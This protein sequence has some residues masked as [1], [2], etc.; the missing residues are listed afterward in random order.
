MIVAVSL[1]PLSAAV[2][3]MGLVLLAV[4][5]PPRRTPATMYFILLNLGLALWALAYAI[6]LNLAPAGEVTL[7]AYGTTRWWLLVA[8]VVGSSAGFTYWFLFGAA[9][10]EHG[11]WVRPAGIALAHVPALYAIAVVLTNARFH[12]F[13]RVVRGHVAYGLPAIPYQAMTFLLSLAGSWMVTTSVLRRFGRRSAG[14]VG[15]ASGVLV[16]ASLL[17]W[18]RSLTG[19]PLPINPIPAIWPAMSAVLGYQ[20]LRYGLADI[21]P[22]ASLRGIMENTDA[23]LAYLDRAFRFV[24]VN[25]AFTQQVRR[26]EQELIGRSYFDLVS[27]H[28]RRELFERVIDSGEGV[29]FRADPFALG[30]RQR[31]ESYWDWRLA[32]VRAGRH[33]SG[34]VLSLT[35]VSQAVREQELSRAL[36]EIQSHVNEAL[37]AYAPLPEAAAMAAS[38]VWADS[39]SIV[40]QRRGSWQLMQHSERPDA[41]WED[42]EPEDNQ[43]LDLALANQRPLAVHDAQHDARVD[44]YVMEL[45]GIKGA[46]VVPLVAGDRLLGALSVEYREVPGAFGVA[47]RDFLVTVADAIAVAV[48]N[49][50][51]YQ[52]ERRIAER[53]QESM[54]TVPDRID[55]LD[56]AHFYRS[57]TETAKVGGDFYDVFETEPGR[58][59]V[60]IGDVAGKGIEAAVVT[61][62]VKNTI[63]AE[64]YENRCP[65]DVLTHA[66]DILRRQLEAEVFV[67]AF[68]GLLDTATGQLSYASAGHPAPLLRRARGGLLALD[69]TNGILASFVGI[70]YSPTDVTLSAGDTLLLF[71]DGV[72]E[73]RRDT[74]LFGEERLASVVRT[75]DADPRALVRTVYERVI[76]YTGDCLADDV[77]LLALRFEGVAGRET[78]AAGEGEGAAKR[79]V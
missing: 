17:W 40:V 20:V 50:R 29:A 69:V 26:S 31:R 58:V 19:V 59:G 60:L 38:A 75:A 39:A 10:R 45:L 15:G 70:A 2:L 78:V 42:F 22:T 16:L 57:A 34:L 41:E 37:D 27:D 76:A 8:I 61:S 71:T 18:T 66:N 35:D 74:D 79:T 64:A 7:A 32:P 68:F 54:L 53:L 33:V 56:F 13:S 25:A 73:A 9:V 49:A 12:L 21:V 47:E 62:L 5:S 24:A 30:D 43:L 46:L 6:D 65:G 63:R 36:Y 4:F 44:P 77:A 72:I 1:L 52:A 28:S 55:G 3:S 11:F 48:Q 67:T 51:L 14:L 23:G